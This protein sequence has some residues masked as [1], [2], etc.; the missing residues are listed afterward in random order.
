MRLV[1]VIAPVTPRVTEAPSS[2]TTCRA[3]LPPHSMTEL[4]ISTVSNWGVYGVIAAMGRILGRDLF[5]L[6]DTES[7]L[8][9]LVANGSV[10]GLTTLSAYSEDGF[11]IAVGLSI[12][13]KLR[14]GS[15]A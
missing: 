7:I 15:A 8:D 4:V 5:N 2:S 1:P 11:P 12:I 9:Y 10:D 6:F 13:D 3:Q 14:N